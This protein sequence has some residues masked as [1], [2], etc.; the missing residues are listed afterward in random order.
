MKFIDK[1]KYAIQGHAITD[2][3]LHT[4][5]T[6]MGGKYPQD[7]YKQFGK[8]IDDAHG[9]VFFRARMMK[10]V[11]IPE[12]A[13]RCCYCMRKLDGCLRPNVEHVVPNHPKDDAEWDTY[14]K[15][16]P[17]V[18]VH[19]CRSDKW[20]SSPSPCPPYPHSVAYEN[21]LA[22]CDGD[23]LNTGNKAATCNLKRAHREVLPLALM[24]D[25][26]QRLVY[27]SNGWVSWYDENDLLGA[28]SISRL[29]LNDE[30]LRLIRKIWFFASDNGV[31]LSKIT[32]IDDFL[33]HLFGLWLKE[34]ITESE[35]RNLFS[36]KDRN[37]WMLL[38][39]FDAFATIPHV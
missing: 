35:K 34:G 5:Y 30:L 16:T 24:Q 26:D 2:E 8:E 13:G 23:L 28:A 29:R 6:R 32:N 37:R 27:H 14:F 19:C 15:R 1:S 7:L 18:N 25:V 31:D 38:L 17:F 3:Y 11:L 39:Q 4:V 36:L 21:L 33:N 20:L 9:N 22:S 10:E 12:Q